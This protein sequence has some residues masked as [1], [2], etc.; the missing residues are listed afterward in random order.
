MDKWSNKRSKIARIDWMQWYAR[1]TLN[2]HTAYTGC[3]SAWYQQGLQR[4]FGKHISV[5]TAKTSVFTRCLQSKQCMQYTCA[6]GASFHGASCTRL[7]YIYLYLYLYLY[8]RE[9]QREREREREKD[10]PLGFGPILRGALL[11][12]RGCV[13]VF[14][15][16]SEG[17]L[18]TPDKAS[19]GPR[20]RH[21]PQPRPSPPPVP[22]GLETPRPHPAPL[23]PPPHSV[24]RA[25]G[26]PPR[27]PG[28][29]GEHGKEI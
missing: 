28:C 11:Q 13:F 18:A 17:G 25:V 12:A 16:G 21:A 7:V 24:W 8:E 27:T 26:S 3:R 10:P 20:E 22:G 4:R 15:V 14:G 5:Y 19:P 23:P 1:Y 29:A 2:D 9:R 6:R